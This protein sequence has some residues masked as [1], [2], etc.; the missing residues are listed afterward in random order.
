M[1][2][3]GSKAYT[4]KKKK[5]NFPGWDEYSISILILSKQKKKRKSNKIIIH[6]EKKELSNRIFDLLVD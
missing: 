1:F 4:V 5:P 2:S 3:I 6:D